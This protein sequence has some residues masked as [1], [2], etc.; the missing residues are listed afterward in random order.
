M[1][2]NWY[3]LPPPP[4]AMQSSRRQAPKED[5]LD[6][7]HYCGSMRTSASDRCKERR[8]SPPLR[9]QPP[10]AGA[11]RALDPSVSC[12]DAGFSLTVLRAGSSNTRTLT[13]QPLPGAGYMGQ[14]M[15]GQPRGVLG[16]CS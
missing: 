14:E 5:I 3:P 4:P 6:L 8:G 10:K 12:V 7:P 2:G 13:S 11:G 9:A 16:Y 1:E 15:W